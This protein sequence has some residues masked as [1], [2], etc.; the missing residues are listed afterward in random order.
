MALDR[1]L[2]GWADAPSTPI[3][4]LTLDS[5]D[6]HPGTAFVA[7][8]GAATHG[9]RHAKQAVQRG[10]AAVLF[11]PPVPAE[12]ALPDNATAV[13]ELRARLGAM[14]DRFYA[15]PSRRLGVVGV[16]GTNGKT[17]TV[18]LITQALSRAGIGAGSIGTLGAGAQSSEAMQAYASEVDQLIEQTLQLTNSK[19]RNDYIFAGTAVDAAPYTATRNAAG[20]QL[21]ASPRAS[22][23]LMKS[24]QALAL[25]DGQEFVTPELIRELAVPA[26]AH[27]LVMQPQARFSGQTTIGVVEEVLKRVKVP[28]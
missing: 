13:P 2:E 1:L 12:I 5:R 16:T 3:A 7:L 11:E 23:A 15:Q 25:F 22:L 8:A 17:S 26:I 20:V 14:A 18:Q 21:G 10:A 24:A 4:G 9:L 19:L 27:R 6:V 28:A